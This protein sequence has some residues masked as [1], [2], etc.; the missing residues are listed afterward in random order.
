MT[1]NSLEEIFLCSLHRLY[2][3]LESLLQMLLLLLK[4]TIFF[5]PIVVPNHKI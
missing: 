1:P 2:F 4:S 5:Q 3:S